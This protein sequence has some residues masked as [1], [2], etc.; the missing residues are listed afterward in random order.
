MHQ[1]CA[2]LPLQCYGSALTSSR[3]SLVQ[4]RHGEAPKDGLLFDHVIMNLPA[5][6]AEFLDVFQGC[7][8]QHCWQ[9]HPLPSIHCYVFGKAG[10]EDAGAR[11]D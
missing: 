1:A 7:F 10:E 3:Q 2:A 9:E 11:P 4:E 8:S 5:S 6:A